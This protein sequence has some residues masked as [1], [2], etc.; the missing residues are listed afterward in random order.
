M[1]LCQL[2]DGNYLAG[3][4][5]AHLIHMAHFEVRM[6]GGRGKNSFQYVLKVHVIKPVTS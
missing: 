2:K 5:Y 4:I 6:V 1:W 3:E